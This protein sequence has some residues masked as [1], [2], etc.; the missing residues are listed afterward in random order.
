MNRRTSTAYFLRITRSY[1]LEPGAGLG[2]ANLRFTKPL[3]YQLSYPGVF[4]FY[5]K[6]INIGMGRVQVIFEVRKGLHELSCI[7]SRRR[8]LFILYP[9][10]PH[11][12]REE[13][14]NRTHGL[15]RQVSEEMSDAIRC[16]MH[17]ISR[18]R[19]K[20]HVI[21][22]ELNTLHECIELFSLV[23]KETHR[24]CS[25]V[26]CEYYESNKEQKGADDEDEIDHG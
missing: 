26:L 16:V 5:L 10:V 18:K 6:N 14:L 1:I 17:L 2:P 7:L 13:S 3:L 21:N 20:I 23:C 4:L 25:L 9:Q 11:E 19:S 15:Q 12:A 24:V 22:D 8:T